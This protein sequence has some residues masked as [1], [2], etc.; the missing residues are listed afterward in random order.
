MLEG[1]ACDGLASVTVNSFVRFLLFGLA[2]TLGCDPKTPTETA[3]DSV[4]DDALCGP[5]YPDYAPGMS[6]KVGTLT[7]ALHSVRP[8][9]PRQKVPNDWSIEIRDESGKPIPDVSLSNP[10]SFMPVHN[11]HGRTPPSI[12]TLPEPGRAQ[13]KAIDFRMRGPWQV[14][15][16]VERA[17]AKVGTATFQICVR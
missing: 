1:R 11:H 10:D 15:F 13:L 7:A 8:T 16:D 4:S 6:V 17:G 3:A 12:A 14:L 9:P 5:T 2:L